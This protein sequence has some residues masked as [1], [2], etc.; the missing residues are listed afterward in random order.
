MSSEHE[1]AINQVYQKV[2]RNVVSF[3]KL[4]DML[5]RMTASSKMSGVASEFAQKSQ[6]QIEQISKKSLGQVASLFQDNMISGEVDL[7]NDPWPASPPNE[8]LIKIECKISGENVEEWKKRMS[9]LI[10]ERNKMIHQFDQVCDLTSLESCKNA[11]TYLDRTH[12]S[13]VLEI[14][15]MEAALKAHQAGLQTIALFLE[16]DNQ[17]KLELISCIQQRPSLKKLGKLSLKTKREDGWTVL[18][19]AV[20]QLTQEENAEIKE[21]KKHFKCKTFK[22]LMLK[23]GVFEFLEEITKKGGCRLLYRVK[24]VCTD[25]ITKNVGVF[26]IEAHASGGSKVIKIKDIV[27]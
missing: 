16:F 21:L 25:W 19:G 20:S 27:S 11:E 22:D 8:P 14:K 13:L 17:R 6:K 3:Y 24:P 26:E 4:E 23:A 7:L 10:E 9:D 18:A 15:N 1:Y 2:G 12:K 5:K